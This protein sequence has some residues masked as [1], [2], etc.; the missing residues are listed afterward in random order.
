VSS[1]WAH[2]TLLSL[3]VLSSLVP[4]KFGFGYNRSNTTM[5]DPNTNPNQPTN[6]PPPPPQTAA[7]SRQQIPPPFAPAR[8]SPPPALF[9]NYMTPKQ[10][11][12]Q[13]TFIPPTSSVPFDPIPSDNLPQDIPLCVIQSQPQTTAN[14]VTSNTLNTIPETHTEHSFQPSPEHK[15]E[16]NSNIPSS[17]APYS[18]SSDLNEIHRLQQQYDQNTL[19][20]QQRVEQMER[21]LQQAY[22]R[23]A[24]LEYQQSYHINQPNQP[25][26]YSN[27]H[28]NSIAKLISKPDTL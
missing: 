24:Q 9:T 2:F 19:V 26:D 6:Q 8:P 17:S 4:S 16:N 3:L 13:R 28:D 11:P 5:S 12:S 15:S 14:T 7:P 20:L 22:E 21:A 23:S 1:H 25:F 18:N 27:Y 10:L